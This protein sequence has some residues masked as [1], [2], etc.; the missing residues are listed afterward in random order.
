MN[1]A[2]R[3]AVALVCTI[4]IGVITNLITSAFSWTLGI[5]L[6]AVAVALLLVEGP[7]ASSGPSAGRREATTSGSNSPGVIADGGSGTITIGAGA[8]GPAPPPPA[9]GPPSPGRG[10]APGDR[11]VSTEGD[12][13]PAV[14]ADGHSGT[15]S[16]G[17]PPD[18]SASDTSGTGDTSGP[19]HDPTP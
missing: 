19:G 16:I 2:W 18:A 9:P 14:I 6:A 13:S 17:V 12:N 5:S 1:Q 15:I 11:H 8:A 4:A 3:R 10:P 7:W